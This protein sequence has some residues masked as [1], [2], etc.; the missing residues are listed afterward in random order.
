MEDRRRTEGLST[1]A[2]AGES[3][4]DQLLARLGEWVKERPL[5]LLSQ[6]KVRR[7]IAN[8]ITTD[9]LHPVGQSGSPEKVERYRRWVRGAFATV[10][11]KLQALFVQRE[12]DVV[13]SSVLKMDTLSGQKFLTRIK[14][15]TSAWVS[16]E[17]GEGEQIISQSRLY[18]D[19]RTELT[20]N[21]AGDR[22]DQGDANPTLTVDQRFPTGA[23]VLFLNHAASLGVIS[24]RGKLK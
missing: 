24:W 12:S 10:I 17:V 4:E 13:M 1:R 15:E 18:D 20:L 11:P 16:E 3:P 9:I 22:Y 19:G 5:G 7:S 2:E 14:R 8:A 23:A 6:R 21:Y